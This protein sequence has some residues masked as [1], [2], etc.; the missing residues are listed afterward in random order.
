MA[1]E[2]VQ[3]PWTARGVEGRTVELRIRRVG[4]VVIESNHGHGSV[5]QVVAS[6]CEG[7]IGEGEEEDRTDY[8]S[9]GTPHYTMT[10]NK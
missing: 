10:F 5:V 1:T 3:V 2:K 8:I 9:T 7:K 6:R 4:D